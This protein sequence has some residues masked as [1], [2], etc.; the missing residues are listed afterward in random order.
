[1]NAIALPASNRFVRIEDK[2]LIPAS[3]ASDLVVL[4]A[5]KLAR[6]DVGEAGFTIVESIYLDS[7][8]LDFL[9]DHIGGRPGRTK[10]RVRRYAPNGVFGR[11][12]FLEAKVKA[13]GIC[14]KDRFAIDDASLDAIREGAPLS[15]TPELA[16]ANGGADAETLARRVSLVESV[17]TRYSAK[18]RV[19]VSYRRIAFEAENLRVTL[20]RDLTFTTAGSV[21]T[22]V[23]S[24][25]KRDLEARPS[26]DYSK[27][28]DPEH[29]SILEVKHAGGQR[30]VD[31]FAAGIEVAETSFSKYCYAMLRQVAELETPTLRL[32]RLRRGA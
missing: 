28:L 5:S 21:S 17:R 22:R 10:L 27:K 29:T 19:T 23:A 30:R 31:A 20:D 9:R 6:A 2:F 12:Q 8:D 14:T 4:L 18:P 26:R 11:A 15:L 25:V 24:A 16:A 32:I 1:M 3:R 13:D 7:P